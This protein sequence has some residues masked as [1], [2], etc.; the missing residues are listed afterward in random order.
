LAKKEQSKYNG[1]LKTTEGRTELEGVAA[2]NYYSGG[3]EGWS[4]IGVD[5]VEMRK[6]IIAMDGRGQ[7]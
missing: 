2:A 7:C 3:E 5:K 4:R 6:E 1:L